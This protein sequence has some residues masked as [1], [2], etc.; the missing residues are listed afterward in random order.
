MYAALCKVYVDIVQRKYGDMPAWD[1]LKY[2]SE[3][4]AEEKLL[5]ARTAQ[6]AAT[7]IIN[8]VTAL[9]L[10]RIPKDAL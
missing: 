5:N 8:Y 3:S 2:K 4:V 1:G 6:Q 7:G 9:Y 10:T